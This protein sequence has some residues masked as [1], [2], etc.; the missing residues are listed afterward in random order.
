MPEFYKCFLENFPA[1]R[2]FLFTNRNYQRIMAHIKWKGE[3]YE[4]A[5]STD[6]TRTEHETGPAGRNDR[7]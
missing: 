4:G 6:P 7:S 2:I 5:P 3:N 1:G